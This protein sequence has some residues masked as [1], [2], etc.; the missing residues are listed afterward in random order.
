VIQSV[1]VPVVFVGFGRLDSGSQVGV[2][3]ASLVQLLL[4]LLVLSEEG[5]DLVVEGPVGIK[6]ALDSVFNSIHTV[7]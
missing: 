6:Y 3:G 7:S 4:K 5:L 1:T 2:V